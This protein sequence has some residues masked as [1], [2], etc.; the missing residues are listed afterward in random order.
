MLSS[1]GIR[2]IYQRE[3]KFFNYLFNKKL[4]GFLDSSNAVGM[5][6]FISTQS[7]A[8]FCRFFSVLKIEDRFI[9]YKCNN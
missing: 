5:A 7:M 2:G 1:R 8:K 4:P 9:F 6:A 3:N